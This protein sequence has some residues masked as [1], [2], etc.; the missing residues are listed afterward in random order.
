MDADLYSSTKCVLEH[1]RPWIV[2]GTWLY[3]DEFSDARHEFRAF[4]EF[5]GDSSMRF[6]AVAECDTMAQVAFVRV[7]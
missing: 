4:T 3:F 5:V 2:Q 6:R 1:L 7:V